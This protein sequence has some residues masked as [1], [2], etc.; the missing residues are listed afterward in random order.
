MGVDLDPEMIALCRR[1]GHKAEQMDALQFLDRIDEASLPAI[2]CAQMI[3]HLTFDQ[4]KEFL[5]L[6]RTRL[7]PDGVLIAETVNPHALEAFK[8]FYTDLTHQRP[9]FPEV[10]LSL[11]RLAGFEQ[12]YVMFP[13]GT[14]DLAEDRES[15]GEYAVVATAGDARSS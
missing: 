12:A 13:L 10:A 8:T 7:R 2:F 6:C 14:G 3:E 9:I 4:L 5:V 15:R 1:K 11:V